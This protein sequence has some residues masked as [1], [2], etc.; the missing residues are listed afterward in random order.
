MIFEKPGVQ[1]TEET[2]KLAVRTA[3]ERGIST[4]VVAS[5]TGR[6]AQA[7][8]NCGVDGLHIVVVTN[9]NGSKT[10]GE[11]VFPAQLRD[12][13][14][15]EGVTFVTATHVLSGAERAFS[16]KFSGVGPTELVAYALRML[17][18][19]LKVCVEIAVMALDCGAI[20]YMEPVV[21]VGGT[22]SGAD[23]AVIMRP[24]HASSILDCKVD[25]ILCKPR[26][27]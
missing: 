10:P 13:L 27:A 2:V 25:E 21:V 5:G 17:G 22:A 9:V 3:R 14:T 11:Q 23:T 1:N 16:R 24:S 6:T 20:S 26:L 4:I 8:M 7:L 12:Q 19:G 15:R 18:Q